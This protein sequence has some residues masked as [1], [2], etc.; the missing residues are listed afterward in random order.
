MRDELLEILQD[1]H[2]DIDFETADNLIDGKILDSFDIVTLVGELCDTF[3][4]EITADEMVPE[5][6]QNL[7]AILALITRKSEED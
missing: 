1:L 3:D 5:N 6:F 2:E 4:I 7:E